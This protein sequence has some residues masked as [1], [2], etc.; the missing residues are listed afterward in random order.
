MTERILYCV[1]SRFL[2]L[3]FV[4]MLILDPTALYIFYPGRPTTTASPTLSAQQSSRWVRGR[5]NTFGGLVL[6]SSLKNRKTNVGRP[7]SKFLA[8]HYTDLHAVENP[9]P[10]HRDFLRLLFVYV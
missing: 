2:Y 10:V 4:T 8:L 3:D 7:C 5:R 1:F 9:H 6:Q